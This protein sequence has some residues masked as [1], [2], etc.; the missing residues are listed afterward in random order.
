KFKKF[1]YHSTSKMQKKKLK[2]LFRLFKLYS[3]RD[4]TQSEQYSDSSRKLFFPSTTFL[5]TVQNK[6]YLNSTTF[7]FVFKF[8]KIRNNAKKKQRFIRHTQ[9]D[10]LI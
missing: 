9:L 10:K 7:C 8:V 4:S 5:M 2:Q 6:K 3:E 1:I